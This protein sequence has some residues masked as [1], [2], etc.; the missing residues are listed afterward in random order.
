MAD[1]RWLTLAITQ[2]FLTTR[3]V[4]ASGGA[5][6]AVE[7]LH[8]KGLLERPIRGVYL[9]P[10]HQRPE[11][12]HAMV[13]KA[14]LTDDPFAA[15]SH[16]SALSLL[17]TP[18][19]HVPINRYHLCEPR[20][21][22]RIGQSVHRHVL[23]DGDLVQRIGDHRITEPALA[24]CQVA[25]LYGA[26]AGAVAIDWLLHTNTCIQDDL[27]RVID[28]GRVRRGIIAARFA[29]AHA[30][31]RAES[32]GET[33]LRHIFISAGV[34]AEVQ[35]H[36]GGPGAGY[37][38][39][40]LVDGQVVIEF[41]G[42]VKYQGADGP[43]ALVKEKRREDW[44]RSQGLQVVRVVWADLAV[45]QRVLTRVHQARLR[46]RGARAAA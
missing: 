23:R 8:A 15:A 34:P 10:G 35:V 28:S 25:G 17:G 19:Y 2:G 6:R 31:G 44:L 18:F 45:P 38:V 42:D 3:Q 24:A 36:V 30:D 1:S 27:I 4:V 40:M 41:D 39:D 29:V 16:H 9:P 22:S 20:S 7:A 46:A 21:S 5:D 33:V 32:P 12:Q 13:V 14:L 11:E 26:L 43:S 37:I